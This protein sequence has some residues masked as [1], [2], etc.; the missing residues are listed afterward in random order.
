[1][2]K[3]IFNIIIIN[4]LLLTI[5]SSV[6]GGVGF[7]IKLLEILFIV[8][9]LFWTLYF[10][11]RYSLIYNYQFL[12]VVS[13][14][15]FLGPRIFLDLVEYKDIRIT[16]FFTDYSVSNKTL[17]IALWSINASLF[18][19]LIPSMFGK[20]VRG[21]QTV[22]IDNKKINFFYVLS[23][24]TLPFIITYIYLKIRF[25]IDYGYIAYH[26]AEEKI[27]FSQFFELITIS[28]YISILV[29]LFCYK[30]INK[31]VF[32]IHYIALSTVLISDGRRGPALIF[33]L[34]SLMVFQYY[35][36]KINLIKLSML[37]ITTITIISVVGIFRYAG[38]EFE[39]SIVDLFYA[40][41]V[42][43][44]P[45]FYSIEYAEVMD[46]SPTNLLDATLRGLRVLF[47]KIF[48]IEQNLD[49]N[50]LVSDYKIYSSYLSST[51]NNELYQ[52]GFGTGGTFIG[53]LYSTRKELGVIIGS[54]SL[55][56]VYHKI[57]NWHN[58]TSFL[59]SKIISFL[60]IGSII[61]VP[62]DNMFD[63]LAENIFALIILTI[64]YF[65]FKIK[66]S[67]K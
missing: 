55:G 35:K 46:Y 1:M 7:S 44:Q 3:T 31:K 52:S 28:Y 42:T 37:G 18:C 47:N 57:S 43:I 59:Y 33:I 67:F 58:K 19:F 29:L 38:K 11:K 13:F 26:K 50:A 62:R 53:E 39:F 49:L 66:I 30:R 32:W 60:F 22:N 56:Y 27:Y 4:S 54:L 10:R 8:Q 64:I 41:G 15:F 65:Y 24:L 40:Q 14:C 34:L 25:I 16:A 51:V 21:Y 23:N 5:D 9:S 48:L 6:L 61:Y 12:I 36:R 20:I 2:E 63:F 17:K 45:I